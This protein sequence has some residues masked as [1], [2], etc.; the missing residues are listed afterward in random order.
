[1]QKGQRRRN[2]F[3]FDNI[4]NESKNRHKHQRFQKVLTSTK[5]HTTRHTIFRRLFFQIE[6]LLQNHIGPELKSHQNESQIFVQNPSFQHHTKT[7]LIDRQI[8]HRFR[9]IQESVNRYIDLQIKRLN[10][11]STPLVCNQNIQQRCNGSRT[12]GSDEQYVEG[13][14]PSP[15]TPAHRP[16]PQTSQIKKLPQPKASKAKNT[17][18]DTQLEA[19]CDVHLDVLSTLKDTS[20]FTYGTTRAHIN[21]LHIDSFK[22]LKYR[23]KKIKVRYPCLH[24]WAPS[25][26]TTWKIPVLPPPFR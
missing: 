21:S 15:P 7:K 12:G 2:N 26:P 16:R 6:M 13:V 1:M 22:Q 17:M 14:H 10:D 4:E 11:H 19:I 20:Y 18:P 24:R 23:V 3:I 8:R 25:C 5:K 9:L